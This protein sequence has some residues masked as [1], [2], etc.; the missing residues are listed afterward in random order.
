M[1][2]F[3]PTA[4][5]PSTAA[6]VE[7]ASRL[8][9]DVGKALGG[10]AVGKVYAR[11]ADFAAAVKKG[12]V[13]V[14]LV[15]ASYLAVAG[16]N[17]TVLGAAIRGG[18]TTH[19]WQLVARGGDRL[20]ALQGKRVLVPS[21]GGRETDFVLDVLLAGEVRRDFFAKI[22][23]APDTASALAA[24]G[25][26]K[27][28]AA[29]VPAGTEL[30]PGTAVVLRLPALAGPVLVAYGSLPQARRAQLAS[31]IASFHGDATVSGFRAGDADAVRAIARR[32]TLPVKRGPLA[33]PAIRL[34][35]GELVD[36]RAF[37][38]ER[39][40]ATAFLK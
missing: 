23:A 8:G 39:T 29:V 5:F 4:P 17:Y 18:D 19:G 25:L 26:G 24:V 2:L 11:A 37:A 16:G 10:T 7:L 21:V 27:V 30:P 36:G 31:A 32:F 12:E 38:I 35:V 28:D 13:A 20:P 15:D 1:G 6:R 33:V 9:E 34:L 40:P 3:A 22:E 14:A